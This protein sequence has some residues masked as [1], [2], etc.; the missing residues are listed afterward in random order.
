MPALRAAAMRAVTVHGRR[1]DAAA[2]AQILLAQ[3]P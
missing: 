1:G 3:Q 2:T